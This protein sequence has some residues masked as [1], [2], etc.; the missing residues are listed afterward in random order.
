MTPE[1]M[2]CDSLSQSLCEGAFGLS[3][4]SDVSCS[5]TCFALCTTSRDI[6]SRMNIFHRRRAMLAA[7]MI[8]DEGPASLA[9]SIRRQ[10]YLGQPGP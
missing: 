1:E 8:H 2:R 4:M 10:P 9:L 3:G 7:H 5:R 6:K